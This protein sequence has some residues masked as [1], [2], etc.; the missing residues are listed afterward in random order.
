MGKGRS[1]LRCKAPL[2]RNVLVTAR[3]PSTHRPL[4]TA[5]RTVRWSV[6]LARTFSSAAIKRL[7]PTTSAAR[8]AVSRPAPRCSPSKM[9]TRFG[10]IAELSADVRRCSCPNWGPKA[11]TGR[12]TDTPSLGASVGILLRTHSHN[13]Q[14]PERTRN[15]G[16]SRQVDTIRSSAELS[17]F[18]QDAT[19]P[20]PNGRNRYH[21]YRP[22]VCDPN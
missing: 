12:S 1:I 11:A 4:R 7:E 5:A 22:N 2:N 21:V 20:H 15:P 3:P 9:H 13:L 14:R 16:A 6:G 17:R 8:I 18:T 19:A 10:E